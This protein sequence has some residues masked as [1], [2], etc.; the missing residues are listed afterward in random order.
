MKQEVSTIK[1]MT[2]KKRTLESWQYYRKK[3][4][5]SIEG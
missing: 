5:T 3:V 4:K 1:K 2:D